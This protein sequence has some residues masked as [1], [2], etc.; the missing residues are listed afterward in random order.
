MLCLRV[1]VGTLLL[2]MVLVF[3]GS[4][5]LERRLPDSVLK[6]KTDDCV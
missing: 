6:E 2:D 5:V 3:S 4:G 1:V